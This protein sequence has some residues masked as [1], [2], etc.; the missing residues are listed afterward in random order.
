MGREIRSHLPLSFFRGVRGIRS[1]KKSGEISFITCSGGGVAEHM[2]C[3]C[4][5]FRE[6]CGG[7]AILG[8]SARVAVRVSGG[9]RCN[10]FVEV[11][12]RRATRSVVLQRKH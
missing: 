12:V 7:L 5:G 4:F 1:E 11:R 3:S 2:R 9:Q 10:D 8:V 6:R